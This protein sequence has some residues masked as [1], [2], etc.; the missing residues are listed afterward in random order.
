MRR[1]TPHL[2]LGYHGCD[3]TVAEA[4]FAGRKAD[5][6]HSENSYDWLGHGI[7]FWEA[8][9]ARALAYARM[10]KRHPRRGR[11]LIRT[12]AV[13]GAILDLGYCLDL[14]EA[15]SIA[16]LKEGYRRFRSDVAR[17]KLTLPVNMSGGS[18]TDLLLRHLD[19]A[20]IEYTHAFLER[21]GEPRL[22]SVRGAFIEGAPIYPSAGFH[23]ENH[24]QICVRDPAC[25]LGYFR[26]RPQRVYR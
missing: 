17:R 15:S 2:I 3:A 10:L 14:L 9:P 5:L 24:I 23:D 25:I 7:Y 1:T 8:N 20:V 22:A 13:V 12:P 26:P 16:I 21:A 19:C 4:I 11:G 18:S 6:R